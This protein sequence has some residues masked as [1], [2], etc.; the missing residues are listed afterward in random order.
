MKRGWVRASP[1]MR[2]KRQLEAMKEH[3]VEAVYVNG[4]DEAVEDFV[5][6][7]RPGDEAVAYSMDRL[8]RRR[9]ELQEVIAGIHQRGAVFVELSTGRRSDDRDALANMIFDAANALAR[10][11]TAQQV[12]AARRNG[13]LGG[14]PKKT[15]RMSVTEAKR[16]WFD[17]R[18]ATIYDAVAKMPGWSIRAAYREFGPRGIGRPGPRRK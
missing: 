13:A 18:N 9:S 7:L 2:E 4:D 8:A 6:S 1:R 5:R 15:D 14:R 17:V 16:E 10:D 12:R 3:Q 11:G